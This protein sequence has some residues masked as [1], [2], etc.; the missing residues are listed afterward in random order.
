[1]KNLFGLRKQ[2]LVK[3]PH[4]ELEP[5][6]VFLDGLAQ[7]KEKERDSKERKFEVPP[8]PKA[9]FGFLFFS[10]AIFALLFLKTF[11]LSIVKG[12][13]LKKEA[14][15]NF[16][17]ITP[18]RADRG[19]VYDSNLQKLVA[20]APSFDL[21]VEKRDLAADPKNL[22]EEII[23]ISQ[24]LKQ[25]PEQIKQQIDK[26]KENALLI[27]EN[28]GHEA[29]I[30]LEA[31][32]DN[33]PGFKL[34]KNIVRD[35]FNGA[36]FSQ[37]LG[38]T[39]RVNSQELQ[40]FKDKNYFVSDYIGKQG[41]EKTYEDI[42]RGTP[43]IFEVQKD[44]LG[45][46]LKEGIIQEAQPGQ[47]LVLWIDGQLQSK[48]FEELSRVAK[49]IGITKGAAVALNP[50]TG[51]VL[52]LVSLPSFDNNVFSGNAS[53]Q[54]LVKILE[55]P[56]QPLFN[57]AISGLYASGSSIKPLV[58][59]AALEEKIIS[60]N[61]QIYSQGFITIKNQYY[62]DIVYTYHDTAPAGWVDMRK[63]IAISCNVY[64][65][66]I[67]GGYLDQKGLGSTRLKNYLN[68]FGWGEKTGIDLP[69]EARGLVPDH[70]W[71]EENIGEPWST[72]DT[73]NL[74]IGQGYLQ[75][76]PLQLATAF[77]AIANQGKLMK[78]QI[79]KKIIEGQ[80][81]DNKVV[82]EFLPQIIRDTGFSEEN[83]KVVLQ[84]MR[85]G[86]IY[87]SSVI[88]NDL[89]VKVAAKTGT[90]QTSKANRYYNWVTVIAPY[91]DP[92]I[93]LTVIL[94]DVPGVRAAALP[95]ANEVLKW[96]FTK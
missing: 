72:G 66:T 41:L 20:N 35:Y 44:A 77:G 51:G 94:E 4:L 7:K 93:V 91:D 30:A 96:Y 50:K 88:L 17:R 48:L 25:D 68:L 18:I 34:E 15:Q 64:F 57:R 92:Q 6:E 24:I 19:I 65:Y 26:A 76:T 67:G 2:Y 28:L 55:N 84:G 95:V 32:S 38:F 23:D 29:I 11:Q 89:P 12:S 45:T 75:V 53:S 52:A 13:D 42:L 87:G 61:K 73:Y 31:E 9:I 58:A 71:K 27:S 37:I 79:V 46:K 22:A 81:A 70:I 90:A 63:A 47:S 3:R 5:Q 86:V 43:G 21:I 74:S 60:P 69:Q 49:D 33:F 78:P 56:N 16:S 10:L 8:S 40:D 62:P 36:I 14:L 80:P 59:T 82:K 1:M 54:D 85:D 39:G 83:L